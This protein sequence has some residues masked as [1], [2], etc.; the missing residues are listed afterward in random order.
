MTMKKFG[1]GTP[2]LALGLILVPDANADA[3]PIDWGRVGAQGLIWGT[4]TGGTAAATTAIFGG[5]ET[6]PPG[7]AVT[8]GVGAVGF[9]GGFLTGA[10]SELYNEWSAPNPPQQQTAQPSP[11]SYSC[12]ASGSSSGCGAGCASGCASGCSSCSSCSG[13]AACAGCA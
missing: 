6:G 1:W 4:G 9:G 12:S 11:A 2:L 13:C 5:S 3:G 8:A 7:W 10:A